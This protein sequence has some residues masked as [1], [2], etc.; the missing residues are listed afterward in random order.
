MSLIRSLRTYADRRLRIP[1]GP[2][3]L[4][5][6]VG[7]GDQPHWRADVIVDRFPDPESA[8]QRFLGGSMRT[9]RPI[10]AVDAGDL[11]FRTGAFDYAVCSHTLEHVPDPAAAIREM[12]RVA[13][14]GYIEVPD[15]SMAK[16]HDF[17]THLWWCSLEG[18]TLVF[19][20]KEGR[21]FD[22]DIARLM[23]DDA[24]RSGMLRVANRNF[25]RCII[26]LHWEGSV[27]V[28][29]EGEPDLRLAEMPA[30]SAGSV[31]YAS[32]VAR[33]LIQR[34]AAEGWNRR[35][36]NRPIVLGE[37]VDGV[38]FGDP[39]DPLRPGILRPDLDGGDIGGA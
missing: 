33:T 24:V 20:A 13:A 16:I 22:P 38:E 23:G 28:R 37:L 39:H 32:N 35:R 4:V 14:R 34:A 5:L 3:E 9:D 30:Q 1:V 11:P 36:R 2:T 15:V 17:P 6:D 8:N 19:R 31:G 27:D 25:D 26:A 10:F 7:G 29:V 21:S 18:D 12:T